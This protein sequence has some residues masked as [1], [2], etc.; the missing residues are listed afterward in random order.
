MVAVDFECV[1]FSG[2][3]YDTVQDDLKK[4]I[5]P[6]PSKIIWSALIVQR[7]NLIR[8]NIEHSIDQRPDSV[9][10]IYAKEHY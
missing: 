4:E 8:D 10:L 3:V 1:H 9:I 2:A 7:K 5:L 6:T